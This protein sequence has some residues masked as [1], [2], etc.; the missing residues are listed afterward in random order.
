[1]NEQAMS[2]ALNAIHDE[3]MKLLKFDLLDEVDRGL[4]LIISLARYQHDVRTEQEK[5]RAKTS[6]SLRLPNLKEA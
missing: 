6:N 3:A 4:Q 5:H 1:M 2:E